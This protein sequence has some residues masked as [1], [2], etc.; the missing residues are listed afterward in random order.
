MAYLNGNV[1]GKQNGREFSAQKISI[2]LA[3]EKIELSGN[4]KLV[5]P[6]KGE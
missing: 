4:A 3:S 5:F 6:D 1:N 2:D